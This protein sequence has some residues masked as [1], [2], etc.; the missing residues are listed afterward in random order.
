[1]RLTLRTLLSYLD[2]TLAPAEARLIGEKLGESELAQELVERIHKV[3]R[4]RGLNALPVDG[5]EGDDFSDPNTVAEYLDNALASEQLGEMEQAALDS[6]AHLAEVASCHQILSL[7]LG[8]PVKV[9]PS[10]RHHMYRIVK[11]R[12]SIPYRKPAAALSLAGHA[13]PASSAE[14]TTEGDEAFL[15][16]LS[17]KKMLIPVAGG[18]TLLVLLVGVIWLA[19]P[20]TQPPAAQGYIAMAG[21]YPA[22]RESKTKEIPKVIPPIVKEEVAKVDPPK[23]I[24]VVTPPKEMLPEPE[25]LPLPRVAVE[26]RPNFIP[27]NKP[28]PD[29]KAIGRV[30]SKDFPLLQKKRG[31]TGW[32]RAVLARDLNSN[33][34]LLCLPG[35][36][37]EIRLETGVRLLLWGNLLEYHQIDSMNLL[38]S[39]VTLHVPAPGL[40]ADFTL[41]AGRVFLS[42]PA[43]KG[44]AFEPAHVRVRFKEEI[45]DITLLEPETEVSVELMSSYTAGVPFSP[46]PNGPTPTAEMNLAILSGKAGVRFDFQEYPSLETA[47]RL[48]WESKNQDR[49]EP[50]KISEPQREWWSKKP[51]D[52]DPSK[53]MQLVVNQ[54]ANRIMK[55]QDAR[56]DVLFYSAMQDP[57]EQPSRRMYA[58]WCLQAVDA[59]D[60]LADSLGED[61]AGVRIVGIRAVQHWTGLA[62]DRDLKFHQVLIGKKGYEDAQAKMVMQLLHPFSRNQLTRP[63]FHAALFVSL[64]HEKVAVRELAYRHLAQADPIG[65][66]EIGFYDVGAPENIREALLQ[67]W[68]ASWKKRF[69]DE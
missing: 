27:P 17:S 5:A 69:G 45:W 44:E 63:E 46:E 59:I 54:Y 37:T 21:N 62:P 19:I 8:E 4:R 1:M 61:F 25:L 50:L 29:R 24:E 55:D 53:A 66:K 9:P 48:S 23:K 15:L 52:T 30:E 42:R 20:A 38:E 47:T 68:K 10:A 14:E 56:Y 49:I 65:A 31:T 36:R 7:V 3:S 57:Q 39:R 43:V 34:S 26:R 2:D 41:E 28:D 33:D 22:P 58:V 67:K 12:E 64:K 51:L 11:G 35:W 40:D 16:G 6:D 18:V 13:D 60:Y 32:E